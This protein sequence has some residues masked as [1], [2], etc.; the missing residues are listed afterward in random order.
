MRDFFSLYYSLCF[1]LSFVCKKDQP[2]LIRIKGKTRCVTF[3][4][5]SSFFSLCTVVCHNV[6]VFE[7][8]RSFIRSLARSFTYLV[9]RAVG[10]SLTHSLSLQRVCVCVC[11]ARANR[12]ACERALS[13]LFVFLVFFVA[14]QANPA[15]ALCG[16]RVYIL[17]TSI[18]K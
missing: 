14:M 9:G 7:Y 1:V 18:F 8:A 3:F 13:F 5:S 4:F 17:F 10:R 6:F 16:F 2:I 12:V 15:M 11:R